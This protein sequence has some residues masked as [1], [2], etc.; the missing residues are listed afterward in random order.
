[1]G[2]PDPTLARSLGCVVFKLG[3]GN[4]WKW[5]ITLQIAV[6]L[7][8]MMINFKWTL[9]FQTNPV[10]AGTP[11]KIK[12]VQ[13]IWTTPSPLSWFIWDTT[14]DDTTTGLWE[15]Q[16]QPASTLL[17]RFYG[18][19][20]RFHGFAVNNQGTLFSMFGV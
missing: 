2:T 11:K 14:T 10:L 1:L 5:C 6:S 18:Y 15:K 8:Q 7:V 3:S 20:P 4:G 17:T 13:S 19:Q 16:L 9:Y 12:Q